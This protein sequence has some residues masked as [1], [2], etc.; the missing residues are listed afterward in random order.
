MKGTKEA[1]NTNKKPLKDNKKAI[2]NFHQRSE[3]SIKRRNS[4]QHITYNRAE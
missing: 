3:K 4:K 1:S 2:N